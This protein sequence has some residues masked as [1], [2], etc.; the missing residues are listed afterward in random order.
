M[1]YDEQSQ[2]HDKICHARP[3]S[4][5]SKTIEGEL[6]FHLGQNIQEWTKKNWW[7]TAFR[8]FE[9]IWTVKTGHITSDFLKAV[10][11]NFSLVHFE[12]HCLICIFELTLMF[13]TASLLL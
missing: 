12:M 13:S 2:M 9:V 7:K 4:N 5:I 8:R 10:F 11:Q 3:N 6:V 1:A